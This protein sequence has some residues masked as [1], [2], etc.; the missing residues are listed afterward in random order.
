M[1]FLRLKFADENGLLKQIEKVKSE[2]EEVERAYLE[3]PDIYRVAEELGDLA[4]AAVTGL[5]IIE[6]THGINPHMVVNRNNRKNEE[7]GYLVQKPL[8]FS[9]TKQM[10]SS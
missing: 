5:W 4:Q 6:R 7:R 1:N 3:E 2:L 10:E 8:D 9:H